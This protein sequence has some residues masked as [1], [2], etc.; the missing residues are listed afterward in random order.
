MIYSPQERVIIELIRQSQPSNISDDEF[1][2]KLAKAEKKVA[3]E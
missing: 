1:F 2:A 3:E